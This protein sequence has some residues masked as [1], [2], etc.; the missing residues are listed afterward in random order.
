LSDGACRVSRGA[1]PRAAK[2]FG[3]G[4]DDAQATFLP[5]LTSQR[6]LLDL[7]GGNHES[8]GTPTLSGVAARAAENLW[9]RGRE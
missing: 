2:T 3:V 9:Q 6:L 8:H 5:P 7:R 1:L 4:S